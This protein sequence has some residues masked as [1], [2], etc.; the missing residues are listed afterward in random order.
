MQHALGYCSDDTTIRSVFEILS[1]ITDVYFEV[2]HI[3]MLLMPCAQMC[4]MRVCAMLLYQFPNR[5]SPHR[6]GQVL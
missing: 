5:F 2:V 4:G 6:E 3:I 1:Q